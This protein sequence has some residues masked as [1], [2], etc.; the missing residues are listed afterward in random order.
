ME[1]G[2]L[3]SF[4]GMM[5]LAGSSFYEYYAAMADDFPFVE[6]H[7]PSAGAKVALLAREP[8]G[9]VGAIIP[10]NTPVS[11]A[12]TKVA[13]ALLAGC[14]LVLKASPEAPTS[15]YLLGE[16]AQDIGLPP[17][18]INCVTADREVSEL[19]VTNPRVDK[20][21]FTGSARQVAGSPRCAGAAWRY[22]LEL[23]ASR[24]A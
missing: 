14:T 13:P 24:R 11:A 8:V 7:E 4:A 12:A 16:I 21:S 20:I 18:V 5:G 15:V 3:Y 19:L 2:A 10:W 6:R 22:T 9:V 1:I 23:A 17:G